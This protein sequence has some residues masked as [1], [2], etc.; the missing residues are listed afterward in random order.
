[1]KLIIGNMNNLMKTFLKNYD[2]NSKIL[3]INKM[4]NVKTIKE[5][6][7][8]IIPFGYITD[9]GLVSNTLVHIYELIISVNVNKII[10]ANPKC[11]D[12]LNKISL[13]Y[14]IPVEFIDLKHTNKRNII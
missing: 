13:E 14:N 7:D 12:I 1:M 10:Y 2:F 6:V 5:D 9:T 8:I 11:C 4:C 3:V